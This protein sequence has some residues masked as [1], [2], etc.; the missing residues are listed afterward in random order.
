MLT[1]IVNAFV[2]MSKHTQVDATYVCKY[3]GKAFVREST[4]TTHMCE[5]KRRFTQEKEQGVQLG[6]QAYLKFYQTTQGNSRNKNYEDFVNSD[7]YIAFVKYGRYQVSIRTIN[8]AS[9][10][11]W[12]LKNNKRLD[13]WTKEDFYVEW[14]K[15][16]LYNESIED[17]LE[18]G[19]K[20]MQSYADNDSIL[21]NNFSNYFRKGSKNRIVSHIRNGRISPWIVYNCDSGIDFLENLNSEQVDLILPW[22]DPEWWQKRFKN[23]DDDVNWLKA[24][25]KEAGL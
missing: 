16:Y 3:C 18:R 5:R 8:F 24:A 12:L 23:S 14:L 21:E 22:I 7:F 9:F 13:Q 25:L 6:F 20:E 10:T 1:A 19:L 11:A 4:L 2:E 15:S 17:A